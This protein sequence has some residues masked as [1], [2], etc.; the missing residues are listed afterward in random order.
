VETQL[1]RIMLEGIYLET[2]DVEMKGWIEK[3]DDLS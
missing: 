1:S 3:T 2:A